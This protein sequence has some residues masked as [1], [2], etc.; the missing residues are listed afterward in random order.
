MEPDIAMDEDCLYLNV[1]TPGNRT[2]EKLPV[3]V[4]YFGG[5]LQVGHTAEM[6]FDGERI[7][8]R[9]IVEPAHF[10]SE[11][12]ALSEGDYSKRDL[13]EALPGNSHAQTSESFD[14]S[15]TGR[16]EVF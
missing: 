12:R 4:W 9:G 3:Y 13:Y 15:R 7:A 11:R 6:E 2:D 16:S 14:G 10:A 5:G 1:W 8:R